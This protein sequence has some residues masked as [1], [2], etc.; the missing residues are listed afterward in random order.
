MSAEDDGERELEGEPDPDPPPGDDDPPMTKPKPAAAAARDLRRQ[1]AAMKKEYDRS[2]KALEQRLAGKE[3][4][5][6]GRLAQELAARNLEMERR[7][8]G[9]QLRYVAFSHRRDRKQT[10]WTSK[11]STWH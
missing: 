1:L 3:T 5:V 11:A 7:E 9:R 8:K 4:E 2:K 10:L 6:Q